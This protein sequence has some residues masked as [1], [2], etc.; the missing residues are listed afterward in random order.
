MSV[1]ILDKGFLT[2]HISGS[3]KDKKKVKTILFP[4]VN[5]TSCLKQPLLLGS[6]NFLDPKSLQDELMCSSCS[7]N[8]MHLLHKGYSISKAIGN[9]S[10]AIQCEEQFKLLYE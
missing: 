1:F 8:R 4:H 3:I 10:T 7:K 6:R 5:A 9:R 2:V